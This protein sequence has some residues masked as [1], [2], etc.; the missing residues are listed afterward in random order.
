MSRSL[1]LTLRHPL[2]VAKAAASVDKLLRERLV[3][4][5][6]TGDIPIEFPAFKVD[7]LEKAERFQESVMTMRKVWG[8]PF[9]RIDS[10]S[11]K[12]GE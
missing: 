4:G 5:I 12:L 1:L 2:H 3:L 11:K 10:P 6:S 9:P 7:P 8:E